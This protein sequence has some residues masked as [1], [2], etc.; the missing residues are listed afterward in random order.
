[1]R[2]MSLF[3]EHRFAAECFAALKL[4]SSEGDFTPDQLKHWAR[5]GLES[6]GKTQW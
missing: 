4:P 1:M 2:L 3:P 5:H 6:A